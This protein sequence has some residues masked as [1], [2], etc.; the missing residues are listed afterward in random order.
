MKYYFWI[1]GCAMNYSDAERIATVLDTL[2]FSRTY[3]ENEANLFFVISCSVRQS[4]IN[5]IYG[6]VRDLKELKEKRNNDKK[7]F[8][9]ILSGCVLGDDK[10][11]LEKVFDI[12]FD[13]KDLDKLPELLSPVI[14]TE[15]EKSFQNTFE[16][17]LGF[18][19]DDIKGNDEYLNVQPHYESTFRAFVPISTGC[20]NFCSY[21]AVPITRGR[22]KSRP[23]FEIITEVTNLIKNGY[24][25]ITLLGQNVN[26]YGNDFSTS[27]RGTKQ[28]LYPDKDCRVV[29]PRNDGVIFAQ[30]LIKLDKIPG[31]H[32]LYFYSNHP[33]D[34]T[35]EL[36]KTILTL[37]HFPHYIHLPLQSGN[38]DILRKMNRH[39]T[40]KEY[41]DLA[42]KIRDIIPDITLT[43]DII[44]GFPGETEK[45]FEDTLDVMKKAKYDMA[46]IAQY[47]PRPGTVS[48][49]LLDDVTETE[50]KRRENIL[51]KEL[52]ITVFEHNKQLID[53]TQRVLI[54]EFKKGKYYGRTEGYKVVEI[55]DF[56]H[57]ER[58]TRVEGSNNKT[59]LIGQFVDVKIVGA[60][61]WKLFATFE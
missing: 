19:R 61:S 18:A 29:S 6:K 9:T 46:F 24:K 36:I 35:D 39:N 3:K 37:R 12:V 31:D 30:L 44:V 22:E 15:M 48:A 4:A 25:E 33:K 20:D 34:M 47:S 21:C 14:S 55:T 5:R 41:L 17:S 56:D 49:K 27:L 52:A 28:S 8:I 32:R 59:D 38:D 11:K 53:T 42:T 50:K 43:T 26:S 51:Q 58:A 54:D 57:P 7:K 23:M 2:G 1:L 16:R 40:K 13:I 10:K 60:E 45:Q